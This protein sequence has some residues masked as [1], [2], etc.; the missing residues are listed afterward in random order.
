[1]FRDLIWQCVPF[2]QCVPVFRWHSPVERHIIWWRCWGCRRETSITHLWVGFCVNLFQPL[3][4]AS[5]L[6]LLVPSHVP[7]LVITDVFSFICSGRVFASKWHGF[8]CWIFFLSPSQWCQNH[9][10]D[11]KTLTPYSVL[12]PRHGPHPASWPRPFCT[13]H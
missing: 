1:M 6:P 10:R 12:A 11:Y 3:I 9:W 4:P 2:P 7:A 8:L 13:Y 5:R